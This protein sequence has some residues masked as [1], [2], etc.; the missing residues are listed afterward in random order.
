MLN[1][2]GI[3]IDEIISEFLLA[4]ILKIKP[5]EKIDDLSKL[6]IM[7]LAESIKIKLSDENALDFVED[8]ALTDL[9][10]DLPISINRD[11]FELYD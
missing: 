3:N 9:H 1:L 11:T 8:I 7:Q 6:Q 5:G 10:V 2:G 4:E